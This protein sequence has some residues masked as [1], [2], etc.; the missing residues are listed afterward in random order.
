MHTIDSLHADNP[1]IMTVNKN[2]YST[3]GLVVPLVTISNPSSDDSKQVCLAIAR[4]H[5]G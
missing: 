1:G 3:G 5:P 2:Q 4:L